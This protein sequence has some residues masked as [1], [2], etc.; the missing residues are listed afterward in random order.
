MTSSLRAKIT[1]VGGEVNVRVENTVGRKVGR[2][3]MTMP[4]H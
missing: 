2:I 1:A 4:K 3:A